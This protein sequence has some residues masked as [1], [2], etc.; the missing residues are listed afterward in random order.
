[1]ALNESDLFNLCLEQGWEPLFLTS[2]N[3]SLEAIQPQLQRELDVALADGQRELVR[4]LLCVLRDHQA[5]D[6]ASSLD[7]DCTDHHLKLDRPLRKQPSADKVRTKLVECLR[8]FQVEPAFLGK[9]NDT[10]L[11]EYCGREMRHLR[12]LERHDIVVHLGEVASWLRLKHQRIDI[13]LR[14][15]R[16][17]IQRSNQLTILLAIKESRSRS[18]RQ[19]ED[20]ILR[21]WAAD[22]DCGEYIEL[23]K[24]LL[25][26]RSRRQSEM[27]ELDE[28]ESERI[29]HDVNK[30]LWNYLRRAQGAPVLAS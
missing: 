28:F 23:L 20:A 7:V 8:G 6:I 4:G 15:S 30:R 21:A 17:A 1:M 3:Q 12:S 25:L 9:A 16:L 13:N 10:D 26:F 14:A 29:D 18:R 24:K 5:E 27:V 19:Y 2:S 22:P 11:A